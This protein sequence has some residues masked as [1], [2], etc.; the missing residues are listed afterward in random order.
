M[1][2]VSSV[3][4]K[5]GDQYIATL[6]NDKPYVIN[7]LTLDRLEVNLDIPGI[8]EPVDLSS[9]VGQREEDAVL[10]ALQNHQLVEV[11][12]SYSADATTLA[13]PRRIY[14]ITNATS[15]FFEYAIIQSYTPSQDDVCNF[16][17]DLIADSTGEYLEKAL[18]SFRSAHYSGP[19]NDFVYRVVAN[20]GRISFRPM[21]IYFPAGVGSTI[22]LR[23]PF[24]ASACLSTVDLSVPKSMPMMYGAMP[25]GQIFVDSSNVMN[26]SCEVTEDIFCRFEFIDPNTLEPISTVK[27]ENVNGTLSEGNV[28]QFVTGTTLY[29]IRLTALAEGRVVDNLAALLNVYTLDGVFVCQYPLYTATDCD[30]SGT[31]TYKYFDGAAL[32]FYRYTFGL[33]EDTIVLPHAIARSDGELTISINNRQSAEFLDFAVH[34]P[35]SEQRHSENITLSPYP[36]R[37]V[38]T[39]NEDF[40]CT[41][42]LPGAVPVAYTEDI[43]F[44][45]GSVI[46]TL[47]IDEAH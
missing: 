29:D 14:A 26:V 7:S 24:V 42:S 10:Y 47:D 3:A 23:D 36:P 9:Y 34:S 40:Y 1:N 31:I 2:I 6:T 28:V 35:I 20:A 38:P 8:H 43:T 41:F 27:V 45:I 15:S 19:E 12:R 25:P 30:Y 16:F 22:V 39:G 46:I 18:Y 37:S 44:Y 33:G 4:K 13:N 21:S 32:S 11:R 5:V 17:S